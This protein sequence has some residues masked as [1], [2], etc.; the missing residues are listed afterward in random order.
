MCYSDLGGKAKP[1]HINAVGDEGPLRGI[2]KQEPGRRSGTG[3]AVGHHIGIA[4]S[5]PAVEGQ[6]QGAARTFPQLGVVAVGDTHRH[7]GLLGQRQIAQGEGL[8]GVKMDHIVLLL[9]QQGGK[10]AV[11]FRQLP[12]AARQREEAD[13]T[14]FQGGGDRKSVV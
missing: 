12:G 11:V 14:F 1:L 13:A 9:R 6:L 8:V 2:P 10:T 5:G 7:P 4:L 3:P